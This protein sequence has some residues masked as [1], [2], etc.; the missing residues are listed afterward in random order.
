MSFPGSIVD[1]PPAG[2]GGGAPGNLMD[3]AR[4][5]RD[6]IP[7][8]SRYAQRLSTSVARFPDI[9]PPR[10]PEQSVRKACA[11]KSFFTFYFLHS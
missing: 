5:P 4:H 6:F 8:M 3:G 2:G 10:A 1:P 7:S 11:N 9:Q